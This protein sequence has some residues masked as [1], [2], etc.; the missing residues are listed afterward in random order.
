M[1]A[2]RRLEGAGQARSTSAQES[3]RGAHVGDQLGQ[4]GIPDSP[5]LTLAEGARFVRFDASSKLP[6]KAF[7][8]WLR[9]HSVPVLRRGRVLLVERRILEA[10]LRGV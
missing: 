10:I 6:S 1:D 2:R 8:K 9:R 4:V 7:R 5:F 3:D